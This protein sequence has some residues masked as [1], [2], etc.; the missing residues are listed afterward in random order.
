M[1]EIVQVGDDKVVELRHDGATETVL[2]K[3][4]SASYE[5][6][7]IGE[8]LRLSD[9]G[10]VD[11]ANYID[12]KTIIRVN[13]VDVS[14]ET[15]PQKYARVKGFFD[16]PLPTTTGGGGT[17][18]VSGFSSYLSPNVDDDYTEWVVS[19]NGNTRIARDADGYQSALNAVWADRT[20]VAYT[21]RS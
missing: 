1:N 21:A 11:G 13:S 3:G 6:N 2:K 7:N 8:W 5:V 9:A 16:P 20:T 14:G 18:T 15:S 19:K 10:G 17:T 12:L 4:L